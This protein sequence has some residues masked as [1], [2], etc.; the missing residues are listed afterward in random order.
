MVCPTLPLCHQATKH[1]V[2]KGRRKF[3][4]D[5]NILTHNR[6]RVFEVKGQLR[7]SVTL[8]SCNV[9]AAVDDRMCVVACW[10]CLEVDGVNVCLN[11][12]CHDLVSLWKVTVC[13][14]ES[15]AVTA[16]AGRVY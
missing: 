8:I 10:D 14:C 15:M 6:Q 7:G 9:T 3:R 11:L 2:D 1:I 12:L 13:D 16:S 5:G 4:F